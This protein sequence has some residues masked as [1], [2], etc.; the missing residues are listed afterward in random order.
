MCKN[1]VGEG[2]NRT[3]TDIGYFV[4]MNSSIFSSKDKEFQSRYLPL[5]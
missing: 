3:R 4:L 1:P 2:A 5:I